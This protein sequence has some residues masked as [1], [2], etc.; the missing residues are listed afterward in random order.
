MFH[1]T[2]NR[3]FQRRSSQQSL[4]VG[5]RKS[6]SNKTKKH[7][8]ITKYTTTQNEHTKMKTGLVPFTTSGPGNKMG[9]FSKKHTRK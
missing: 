2:H 3:S 5:D 7:T 4:G 9:L 8:S 6:K 1:Q